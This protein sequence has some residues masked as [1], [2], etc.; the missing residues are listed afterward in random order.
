MNADYFFYTPF[1]VATH[2]AEATPTIYI[3][4]CENLRP[5]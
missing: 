5:I 1:P 2:P 4:I 3:N